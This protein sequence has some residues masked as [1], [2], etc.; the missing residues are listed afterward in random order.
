[1]SH[2]EKEM[3]YLISGEMSS[4]IMFI[5][6]YTACALLGLYKFNLATFLLFVALDVIL[7]QGSAYWYILLRRLRKQPAPEPVQ[8]GKIYQQ[9]KRFDVIMLAAVLVVTIL[10]F[11]NTDLPQFGLQ[12]FLWA[13]TV[14]EYINYFLIRLSFYG[15]TKATLQVIKPAKI[16]LSGQ[17][18]PSKLSM[19]IQAYE[20]SLQG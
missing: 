4:A 18:K 8:V 6:L 11:G 12:I 2:L 13:F 3:K 17:G 9:F 10:N 20:N 19:E 5:V 7:L 15:K 1:M 14:I 16:L